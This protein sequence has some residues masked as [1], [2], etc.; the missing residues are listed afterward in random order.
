MGASEGLGF[1]MIDGQMTGRPEVIVGALILFAIAG[2]LSDL[3]LVKIT[4]RL[5]S[6]QDTIGSTEGSIKGSS[7]GKTNA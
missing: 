1:L 3:L 4:N 7:G 5:L 6:W 2:K